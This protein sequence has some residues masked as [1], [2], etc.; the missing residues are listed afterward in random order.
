MRPPHITLFPVIVPVS[1][2]DRSLKGREKVA[3]LSRLARA[4][5]QQSCEIS[6]L[7]LPVLP[8]DADGVP[9]PV[10]GVYWSLS[11]K[12]EIAGGVAATGPVGF[13]LETV[14]P[15]K[16]ALMDRVADANEW[17]LIKGGRTRDNFFRFWTAKEAVLKAT[18]KGF[19]G[20]S[21]CR[22]A[23]VI[24]G[25]NMLLTFDGHP[26]P[27]AQLRFGDHLAA[28]TAHHFSVQWP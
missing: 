3:C 13:D 23:E 8:K 4:A 9:M 6:G 22:I 21:R 17:R 19:V 1:K 28:V 15:F 10:E 2:A 24:D 27:I 11:H 5:L 14:R 16:P 25:E 7:S 12:S 26:W 18:G 20:I